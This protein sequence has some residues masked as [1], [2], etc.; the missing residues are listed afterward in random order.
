MK[1][2]PLPI[3]AVLSLQPLVATAQEAAHVHGIAEL[4]LAIEGDEL[5]IE[6]VSP[7]DNIVGFEHE[8]ATDAEREAIK[9]AIAKLEDATAMFDLPASAG[10]KLHEAEARHTHDEHDDHGHEARHDD[11]DDHDHDKAQGEHSEF[12][13]HYHFDCSGS[14]IG[15]VGLKLF[16][17][18][19]R[20]EE[21]HLQALTP[22]GQFGGDIEADDPVIRLK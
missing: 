11:H 3:I 12:H 13:A 18:W 20:I 9:T 14:P 19:P 17:V 21:I 10:C 15:M 8:A 2:I 4:N 7:A 5:E 22:G 6:F 16:K 1:L